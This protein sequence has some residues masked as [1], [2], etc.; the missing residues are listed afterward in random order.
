MARTS[1]PVTVLVANAEN[2]NPATTALDATNGHTIPVAGRTRNILLRIT[3]TFAGSKTVT[4]KAGTK[5]PAY[6][7]GLG[8]L[9]ITLGAQNDVA[10]VLVESGR[11]TQADGSIWIDMAAATTGTIL[12]LRLPAV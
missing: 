10:Y 1:V 4:V 3:N 5:P 11:F 8:D 9:V 12:A 7:S 6:R 2:E